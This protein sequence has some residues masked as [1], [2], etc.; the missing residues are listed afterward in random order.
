MSLAFLYQAN[1]RTQKH[2]AW[3][4]RAFWSQSSSCLRFLASCWKSDW[5]RRALFNP[6]LIGLGISLYFYLPVEPPSWSAVL[7]TAVALTAWLGTRGRAGA[8]ATASAVMCLASI[9]FLVA[10]LRTISIYSPQI[11]FEHKYVLLVGR[12]EQVG[13]TSKGGTRL[14]LHVT[15]IGNEKRHTP[16]RLRLSTSK[17]RPDIEIGHWVEA[18]ADLN[19]M[20]PPV[21]PFGFDYAKKL[22]FEGVRGTAFTIQDIDIVAAPANSSALDTIFVGIQRLRQQ[23]SAR[24][25]NSMSDR[26]G[27]VAAAL[28]TGERSQISQEDNEAMRIS[29]LA[30][31]LSISGLHMMLAGFGFFSAFRLISSLIPAMAQAQN[32]KKWAA[33]VSLLVSFLYLILSGASVPTQRAFVTVMLAFIAIMTDRNAITM[34]T[35]ALA[36][37][38]ILLVTPEAWMDPSF[39][40][41]FGAVVA[42]ISAYEWWNQ[43]R[44]ANSS[45]QTISRRLS[46]AV[47]ATAATSAIA[48]L[49]TAPFAAFHFNRISVYGVAANVFVM[50]IVSLIIM[51]S[52]VLALL[53]MPIGLDW[54]PLQAMELG[55]LWMLDIAHWIAA[56]PW[57][58]IGVPSFAVEALL[59]LSLGLLWMAIWQASWRWLSA[60]VLV[61]AIFIATATA[62]DRP[63]ILVSE[64][65][66]NVA[67]RSTN[68][69]L[70]FLS[71]R[72]ARFDAEMW[73]RADGETRDPSVLLKPSVDGFQCHAGTCI[74]STTVPSRLV[75]VTSDAQSAREACDHASVLITPYQ[76]THCD[77]PEM[78]V[79]QAHL[80]RQGATAIW[81]VGNDMRWISVA[82]VRGKRP[83]VAG[84]GQQPEPV[85]QI[86]SGGTGRRVAPAP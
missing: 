72:H 47:L 63:S 18:R 26:A 68:D 15:R 60:P 51:P 17:K 73:I 38:F 21:M 27:P 74:A 24:I 76:D 25:M 66:A 55:L 2:F 37:T 49:A 5:T 67:V 65:G 71:A 77:G 46:S 16:L 48:G 62:N 54:L 75:I 44:L 58:S 86:S 85:D 10:V 33:A 41:S 78:V 52:G 81:Q 61:F 19:P 7:A 20:P 11:E 30:H 22:W 42:L 64:S 36:A 3:I 35:V 69:E 40:M 57:A 79:D 31:L 59:L 13:A 50:P 56:W 12:V 34:R 53:L 1:S 29:S 9:G 6:V 70:E 14:T 32:T 8:L 80:L 4:A 45:H 82:Q 28:L 83:W 23:I 43:R 84:H 39:Q